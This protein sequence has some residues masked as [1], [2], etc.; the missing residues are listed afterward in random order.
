MHVV[1]FNDKVHL[2]HKLYIVIMNILIFDF[3][4]IFWIT[5]LCPI[6]LL[7]PIPSQKL[8]FDMSTKYYKKIKQ[9]FNEIFF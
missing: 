4:E 5:T 7:Q 3:G 8:N 2:C 1:I 6:Q 9:F